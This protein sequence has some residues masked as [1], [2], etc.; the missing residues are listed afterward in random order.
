MKCIPSARVERASTSYRSSP[1]RSAL[2]LVGAIGLALASGCGLLAMP[3]DYLQ[4]HVPETDLFVVRFDG[5]GERRLTVGLS[6]SDP[7]W[8]PDGQRI[9]FAAYVDFKSLI[10]VTNVDGS[11]PARLTDST[12][13][14]RGP[15]WSRDGT[16]LGFASYSRDSVYLSVMD[17]IEQRLTWV[18]GDLSRY[19]GNPAWSPAWQRV[20]WWSHG[21]IQ[22][23]VIMNLP[24][25]EQARIPRGTEPAWSPDGERIVFGSHVDQLAA[26][27]A[28]ALTST[29]PR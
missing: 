11:A 1:A 28:T 19:G 15:V 14:N 16:R 2:G 26:A 10:Y 8:S 5:T 9:A 12:A 29:D 7:S 21:G 6:A 25:T 27:R 3:S 24:G 4:V 17:V 18:S 23:L 22:D 20:A 13:S